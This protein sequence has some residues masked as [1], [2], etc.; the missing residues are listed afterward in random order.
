MC[1]IAGISSL[2]GKDVSSDLRTMLRMMEHRGPDGVGIILGRK[3]IK[4]DS[5]DDVSIDGLSG[6]IGL[7]HVRLAIVGGLG[8][9][10]PLEDCRGGI[11][12]MHNGEVYNYQRL[13]KKLKGRHRFTTK[14]DS[15]VIPHLIE[16]YYEGDLA[17]A[18]SKAV[19]DIDGVYALA[20]F[21]GNSTVVARDRLGVRQ[22]Y[23]GKNDKIS[24]F[25]SEKKALW[26]IG[27]KN[28]S[29]LPPGVVASIDNGVVKVVSRNPCQ[30]NKPEITSTVKAIGSYAGA[31]HEAILKRIKGVK[32]VGIIFSGGIDSV[33][34]AQVARN[35][36][37]EVTC[38]VSGLE[39][40]GDIDYARHSAEDLGFKHQ[41]RTLNEHDIEDILPKVIRAIEDRSSLQVEVAIPIFEAVRMAHE[42]GCRVVLTGQAA[43]ELFAGYP[44][45][46][47]IAEKE[48][49]GQLHRRMLDD[50][51][52]LFKE[53]L[54][55]EDKIAMWH[56]VEMRV[57]YLD[58]DVV[59]V[60]TNIDPALNLPPGDH[61]GKR[62][63]REVARFV[64]VPEKY[65]LR[66]KAAAQHGSGIH[67]AIRKVAMK[68]GF[69][70]KLVDTYDYSADESLEE[71]LGSS[72][73]YGYQYGG[74]DIWNTPDFVQ[75]YLDYIAFKNGVEDPRLTGDLEEQ[76][77]A[78][79]K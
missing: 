10:Q 45:Y 75:M 78:L 3:T 71:Q 28:I 5:L 34:I 52:R 29:R 58:L 18:V 48:G 4:T 53:T 50:T 40:S 68:N 31:L 2:D 79:A 72:Q 21:D 22:L 9:N 38:Y 49:Y 14:T 60:A 39:G 55:R 23:F 74:G 37:A 27:L 73:R 47:K 42:D 41:I 30:F 70:E 76:L 46:Q 35:L 69:S 77:S 6:R 20:V 15:E 51:A 8:W 32:K 36:G 16:G 17:Q 64:G 66:P 26:R 65:A 25:A 44:W 19:K 67:D 61:L 33:L 24:A 11:S 63:H 1:G 57:P 59:A 7:G 56:S 13:R 62:I 12:V 54:E 43:D